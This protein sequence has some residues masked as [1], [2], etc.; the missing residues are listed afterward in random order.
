MKFIPPN[1]VFDAKGWEVFT[2]PGE[3]RTYLA[4]RT[5]NRAIRCI[6]NPIEGGD[7]E[8]HFEHVCRMVA[9]VK[10]VVFLIDEVDLF[11]SPNG[12]MGQRSAFWQRPENKTR[13]PMFAEMLDRGRHLGIALV[14]LSRFPAQV[15]RK[16]TTN[17]QEMRLFRQDEPNV[18]AYYSDKLGG[19]HAARIPQL[20]DYEYLLWQDG[21]T[22]IVA[23]GRR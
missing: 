7:T 10:N 12:M 19:Q 2:Q 11:C 20:G 13:R 22:P 14:M 8:E 3:L 4:A 1:V 18:I 23:G 6:Y 15:H 21:R 9:A 17:C 16:V 5:G